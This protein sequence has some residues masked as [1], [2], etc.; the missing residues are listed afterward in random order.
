MDDDGR[1]IPTDIHPRTG[2]SSLETVLTVL[3]AGGKFGGDASGYSVSGGLHGVG[4]SVVN[5]LSQSLEV[6]VWRAGVE[7]KQCFSCGV[8]LGTMSERPDASTSAAG[9]SSGSGNGSSVPAARRGTRVRYRFDQEV[10][11]AG[12]VLDPETIR[13]RLRELAFLNSAV[14]IMFRA[15][16]SGSVPD[17]EEVSG[18]SGHGI[19]NL[20]G[21]EIP[22]VAEGSSRGSSS[23]KESAPD[24]DGASGSSSGAAGDKRKK[25][26]PKKST[27]S[28][29]EGGDDDD[30]DDAT[31]RQSG[32]DV[33]SSASVESAL[34]WQVF[35][36]KGGLQ[37]YVEWL[38][39]GKLSLHD[40]MFFTRKVEGMQVSVGGWPSYRSLG[41]RMRYVG[42]W[43]AGG[44]SKR[45]DRCASDQDCSK[46]S[47]TLGTLVN[48]EP[49]TCIF[50]DVLVALCSCTQTSRKSHTFIQNVRQ[51]LD[52]TLWRIF[53]T[54][55]V[56]ACV[57]TIVGLHFCILVAAQ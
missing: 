12:V 45:S 18:A 39:R 46:A 4:I 14:K 21:R 33:S 6:T 32:A 30:D 43:R 22:S 37:E 2:K 52:M 47:G 9:S 51:G 41:S 7:Y 15:H 5:A 11:A 23:E 8:A 50:C 1:G 3:H 31:G 20:P 38:N 16:K 24:S 27:K 25:G 13:N 54:N 44:E 28:E 10:F 26:S 57:E 40:P 49:A 36:Y 48:F 17:F 34:D 29:P 56:A 55:I 19:S 42:R 53:I 35:S